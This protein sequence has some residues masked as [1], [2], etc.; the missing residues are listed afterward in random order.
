MC[1]ARSACPSA[2]SR[3]ISRRQRTISCRRSSTTSLI[4][5]ANHRALQFVARSPSRII[6]AFCKP[7]R[8]SFR[9]AL[10]H[11]SARNLGEPEADGSRR[12][13]RPKPG[14]LTGWP[15][16]VTILS[17]GLRRARLRG[18]SSA[19]PASVFGGGLRPEAQSSLRAI[20][21]RR[22]DCIAK[23]KIREF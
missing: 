13:R 9:G 5:F 16:R 1:S 8:G 14:Q 17:Q 4:C 20:L 2:R 15:M 19:K 6:S 11:P 3:S 21:A 18:R 22:W 23:P 12:F 10:L 7:S